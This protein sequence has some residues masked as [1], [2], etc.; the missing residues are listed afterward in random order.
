MACAFGIAEFAVTQAA[1]ALGGDV[2]VGF[3]NNLYL[4]SGKQ[5]WSNKELVEIAKQSV[6]NTSRQCADAQEIR[7]QFAALKEA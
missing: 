2:R 6:L 3:E 7:K 4:P 1:V 5:A